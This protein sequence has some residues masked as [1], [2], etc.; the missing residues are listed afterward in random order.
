MGRPD[1]GCACP[2]VCRQWNAAAR[3]GSHVA[4]NQRRRA[5]RAESVAARRSRSHRAE[6]RVARRRGGSQPPG[7]ASPRRDSAIARKSAPR[8]CAHRGRR[9]PAME[10]DWYRR[11]PPAA[12]RSSA[13]VAASGSPGR[14]TRPGAQRSAGRPFGSS[15]SRRRR[16]GAGTADSEAAHPPVR[17]GSPAR[18]GPRRSP[19][20]TDAD[21][22]GPRLGGA[23]P[24]V[25]RAGRR[26]DQT[27]GEDAPRCA[28]TPP[29]ARI[30]AASAR[31]PIRGVPHLRPRLPAETR[32]AKNGRIARRSGGGCRHPCRRGCRN[33]QADG[34]ASARSPVPR[35]EAAWARGRRRAR[36]RGV[37]AFGIGRR[38]SEV[39][40]SVQER[41]S[42]RRAPTW[43][44]GTGRPNLYGK[45][46]RVHASSNRPSLLGRLRLEILRKHY[47]RGW[48]VGLGGGVICR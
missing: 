1:E 38:G 26:A 11:P 42:P 20:P 8:R 32:S 47:R 39:L 25:R 35:S 36:P 27:E 6:A 5:R 41:T 44:D 23:A 29:V 15:G 17:H 24:R 12:R 48:R 34:R 4:L 9:V 19:L 37:G 3:I 14:Q 22:F 45:K 46:R 10:R 43:P 31:S 33:P 40:M 16:L 2:D 7:P 30:I 21:A 28:L 18:Q 13:R